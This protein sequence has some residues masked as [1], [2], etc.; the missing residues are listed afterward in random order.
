M[1]PKM[2]LALVPIG[3]RE[4][5]N[6]TLETSGAVLVVMLLLALG[7]CLTTTPIH[8]LENDAPAR[9]DLAVNMQ[10][11]RVRM[12][13]LV[14]PLSAVIVTSADRI[15]EIAPNRDVQREALLFKIEAVPALREALFRP[16]PYNAILDSWVLT[17]QMSDYF[18]TGR[19]SVALGDAAPGAVAACRDL[20]SRIEAVAASMTQSG[21][22]TAIRDFARKFA[23]DHPIHDSIIGRE[24]TVSLVTETQFQET[25]STTEV[26]G[27]LVVTTDD[28]IRRLDVYSDQLLHEARWQAELF[29]MDLGRIYQTDQALRLAEKAVQ[30]AEEATAAANRLL[31]QMEAAL[32]SAEAAPDT[33]ARE[34]AAAVEA[35][36]QELSRTIAFVHEERVASLAHV[37]GERRAALLE[38]GRLIEKEHLQLRTEMERISQSVVEQAF[39]RGVQLTAGVLIAAFIGLF[40]L[41]LAARRLFRNTGRRAP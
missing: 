39:I 32:A 20:E 41:L 26:A 9:T 13:A 8:K 4:P 24:S 19:G 6:S 7:G 30:S 23:S 18:E 29:A 34:R 22:V 3:G 2:V 27:S 38:L 33:I 35:I 1:N 25:F 31:P 5:P 15:R 40:V 17:R 10:Q 11:V 16:H 36:A 14:E 21:D 28:L 12:R 37:T